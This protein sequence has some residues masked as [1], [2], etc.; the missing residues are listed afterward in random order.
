MDLPVLVEHRVVLLR[1]RRARHGDPHPEY[2]EVDDRGSRAPELGPV[3]GMLEGKEAVVQV[4]RLM[5]D[6]AADLYVTSDDDSKVS[7]VSPADG[8]LAATHRPEVRLKGVSGGNP[9]EAHIQIRFGSATGPIVGVLLARCFAKRR[10]TM[11]PH[12]VTIANPGGAGGIAST[13][14]VNAIMDH[15][16]AIWRACG[17]EFTVN[18]TRNETC[19]FATPGVVSDTP[20]PNE[21]ATLLGTNSIPNT[22]NVYFV[23]QIGVGNFLGYGFS[24][25]SSVSSGTGNPGIILADR[26]GATVHDTAWAG[27]DLAHESGHFFQLWHSN[28]QEIPNEREDTWARRMLM[29]NYNTQPVMGN[30]K[31]DNGYGAVGSSA[32]RGGLVTHKHIPH[33]STDDECKTA[34]AAILAGPY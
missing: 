34:R 20:W 10:V 7:V 3:V 31:D 13:A 14:N 19:N 18:A 11:T 9:N 1:W 24:R 12:L 21:V 16:R 30:W 4:E 27:N 5:I 23:S 26:A 32:R 8:K 15:V 6:D 22:I 29:H 17:V 28:H 33:I 2:P 25:P